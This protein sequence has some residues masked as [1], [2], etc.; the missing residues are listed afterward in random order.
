MC[1]SV[2]QYVRISDR[3][4]SDPVCNTVIHKLLVLSP[5]VVVFGL[6]WHICL[7]AYRITSELC[8]DARSSKIRANVKRALV[9]KQEHSNNSYTS[10]KR[11]EHPHLL[12]FHP[13]RFFSLIHL[14][15]FKTNSMKFVNVVILAPP[16]TVLKLFSEWIM[17][18]LFLKLFHIFR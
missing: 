4:P 3:E 5:L 16:K 9:I 6:L 2:S 11:E 12:V 14:S 7:C 17:S 18:V 13:L 15:H 8:T 1:V 10:N